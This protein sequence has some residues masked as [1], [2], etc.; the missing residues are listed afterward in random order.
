MAISPLKGEHILV[1]GR[2]EYWVLSVGML[3]IYT[4]NMPNKFGPDPK[5]TSVKIALIIGGLVVT[6]GWVLIAASLSLATALPCNISPNAC[7]EGRSGADI[8]L[9]IRDQ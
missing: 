9:L 7:H 2:S 8:I 5:R 3:I 1:V 4:R 6:V